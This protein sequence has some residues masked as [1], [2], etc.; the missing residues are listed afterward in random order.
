MLY[1]INSTKV[2]FKYCEMKNF[3]SFLGFNFDL[4]QKKKKDK[5]LY[6]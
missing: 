6:H 1:D 2:I 4:S 5:E 3:T